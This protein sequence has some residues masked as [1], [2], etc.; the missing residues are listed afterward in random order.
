M[1]K[2]NHNFLHL[3]NL[4]NPTEHFGKASQFIL[5]WGNWNSLLKFNINSVYFR[6]IIFPLRVFVIKFQSRWTLLE[7][8]LNSYYFSCSVKTNTPRIWLFPTTS[9]HITRLEGLV[10]KMTARTGGSMQVPATAP[11]RLIK[12]PIMSL[13]DASLYN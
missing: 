1:I 2:I 5:M 3:L 7:I 11:V 10:K 6:F 9:Y 12:F 13:M 4:E 8:L